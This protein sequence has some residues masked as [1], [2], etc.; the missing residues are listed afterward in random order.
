MQ[1]VFGGKSNDIV[2]MGRMRFRGT[3]VAACLERVQCAGM[4]IMSDGCEHVN[5]DQISAE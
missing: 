5:T 1:E 2:L 4:E 3:A